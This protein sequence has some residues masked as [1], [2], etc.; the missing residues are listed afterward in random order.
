MSCW[1]EGELRAWLDGELSL[2]DM[3][4]AAAHINECVECAGL[5]A[6]L[7]VRSEA[8]GTLLGYLPETAGPLVLPELPVRHGPAWRWVVVGAATAAVAALVMLNSP[9]PL[10][11]PQPATPAIVVKAAAP[12][13]A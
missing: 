1:R 7:K 11:A 6:E 2:R 3:E 4:R 13:P 5:S 12:A 9:K 8:V 10:P